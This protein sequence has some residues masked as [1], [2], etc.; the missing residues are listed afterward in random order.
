VGC[1]RGGQGLPRPHTH[2]PTRTCP[3]PHAHL[4]IPDAVGPLVR[5]R[6]RKYGRTL[7]A[8]YGPPGSAGDDDEDG[9]EMASL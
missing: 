4:Q 3:I 5:V 2:A 8:V 6:G 9:E 7:V 1:Q